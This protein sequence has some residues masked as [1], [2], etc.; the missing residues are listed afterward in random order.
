[1]CASQRED[2]IYDDGVRSTSHAGHWERF[3]TSPRAEKDV[4]P[5]RRLAFLRSHVGLG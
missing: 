1:M 4:L 5:F 3:Q 2:H